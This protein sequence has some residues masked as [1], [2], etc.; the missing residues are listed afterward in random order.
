VSAGGGDS[1]AIFPDELKDLPA[2][3]DHFTTGFPDILADRRADLD[4]R[5]VHLSLDEVVEPG[6]AFVETAPRCG[7]AAPRDRST[8][9][10]SSS[11]PSV[12]EGL[13]ITDAHLGAPAPRG[14]PPGRP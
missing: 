5:L 7:T 11:I 13:E 14:G 4:H 10:N 9:W 12:N 2:E 3:A 1:R 8:T 6:L